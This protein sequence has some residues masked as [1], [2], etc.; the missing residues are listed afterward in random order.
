[1]CQIYMLC[2]RFKKKYFSHIVYSGQHVRLADRTYSLICTRVFV[3]PQLSL[4]NI[5]ITTVYTGDMLVIIL[6]FTTKEDLSRLTYCNRPGQRPWTHI[7][8]VKFKM[9]VCLFLFP[10]LFTFNW[11][12]IINS[13]VHIW[14][15][16]NG[17][18]VTAFSRLFSLKVQGVFHAEVRGE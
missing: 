12:T 5:L 14:S 7:R 6:P 8:T 4:D 2:I 9:D 11:A 10:L 3:G 15:I 17:R 18:K 13:R 1:M 16:K